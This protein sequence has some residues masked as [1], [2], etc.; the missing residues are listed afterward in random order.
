MPYKIL[1][2]SEQSES[3]IY[4]G[5]HR[6]LPQ[7]DDEL[8]ENAPYNRAWR[9]LLDHE[10]ALD[11]AAKALELAAALDPS[12]TVCDVLKLEMNPE[13]AIASERGFIGF[14]VASKGW[15]STLSWGIHWDARRKREMPVGPLI[16]L[17][18]AHFRP[19]LNEYGL[20]WDLGLATMFRRV[21]L[22]SQLL[23]P[24]MWEADGQFVPE[25]FGLVNLRIR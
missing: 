2:R 16:E 9:E 23:V 22:S 25:V 6:C 20:F 11:C 15:D 18:E 1:M 19:Q 7:Y 14:D 5:I 4:R 17:I 24:N 8:P 13:E 10:G 21:L 12:G 3:S